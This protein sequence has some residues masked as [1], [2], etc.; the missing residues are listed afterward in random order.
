MGG[1]SPFPALV[2]PLS[3]PVPVEEKK[4]PLELWESPHGRPD[5][6]SRPQAVHWALLQRLRKLA[7]ARRRTLAPP[8]PL[9]LVLQGPPQGPSRFSAFKIRVLGAARDP[10]LAQVQGAP[11]KTAPAPKVD[12]LAAGRSCRVCSRGGG[13]RGKQPGKR[14]A[15]AGLPPHPSG[16]SWRK[17]QQ[18]RQAEQAEIGYGRRIQ[19]SRT[20]AGVP[21]R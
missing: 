11:C 10:R 21:R 16:G 3:F 17:Q 9:E 5:Q 8:D 20:T 18:Q 15:W 19:D 12:N 2:R 13:V 6:S 1:L 4:G 14:T 7:R